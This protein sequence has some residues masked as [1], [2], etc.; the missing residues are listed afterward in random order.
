M[1]KFIVSK[2]I[3]VCAIFGAAESSAAIVKNGIRYDVYTKAG[4]CLDGSNKLKYLSKTWC[5]TYG[6]SL[7]WSAPVK[8][9]DGKPLTASDIRAYEVYWTRNV[10]EKGGTI[11]K[12]STVDSTMFYIFTPDTYHFAISAVDLAGLKSPLS[13]V[14]SVKMGK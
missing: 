6:V 13:K 8:R 1:F 10:D 4:K 7:S 2:I 9:T 5:P 12:G 11:K 3:L 14:V